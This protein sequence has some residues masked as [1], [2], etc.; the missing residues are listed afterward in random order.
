MTT[1]DSYGHFMP[2]A[3]AEVGVKLD[4]LV[5]DADSATVALP[6][7]PQGGVNSALVG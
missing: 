5:F 2:T 6:E 3:H 1:L 7:V 4:H